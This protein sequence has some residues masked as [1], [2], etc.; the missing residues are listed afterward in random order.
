VA[1]W[2]NAQTLQ[3][4]ANW[5]RSSIANTCGCRCIH[6]RFVGC[7]IKRIFIFL[8]YSCNLA[9]KTDLSN[10]YSYI[11]KVTC[12]VLSYTMAARSEI[13]L[14]CTNWRSTVTM[15]IH[16]VMPKIANQQASQLLHTQAD[17]YSLHIKWILMKL[18][19][20]QSNALVNGHKAS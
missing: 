7:L 3:L 16:T 19:V 9:C 15:N 8:F 11:H 18:T 1:W 10:R 17:K 14:T 2:L 12:D 20:V 13:V 4:V 6:L 5:R